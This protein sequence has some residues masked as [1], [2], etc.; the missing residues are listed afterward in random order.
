MA[1]AVAV[2]TDR[3]SSVGVWELG[4]LAVDGPHTL[5]TC[6]GFSQDTREIS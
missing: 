2:E 4:T 5:S 3:C 6:E 1:V